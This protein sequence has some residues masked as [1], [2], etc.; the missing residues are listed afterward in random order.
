M[1]I[2]KLEVGIGMLFLVSAIILYDT[3]QVCDLIWLVKNRLID[4]SKF[5]NWYFKIGAKKHWTT[6]W[7]FTLPKISV[8]KIWTSVPSW[9]M[10]VWV[11][12]LWVR[13]GCILPCKIKKKNIA[14]HRHHNLDHHPQKKS[15]YEIRTFFHRTNQTYPP[16]LIGARTVIQC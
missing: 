12:L 7:L 10:L 2:T 13:E 8:Y 3:V 6:I 15:V 5:G 14:P 9:D 11:G 1:D 16:P 4:L